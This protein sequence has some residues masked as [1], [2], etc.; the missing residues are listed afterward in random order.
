MFSDNEAYGNGDTGI[1]VEGG[2]GRIVGNHAWGN[3]YGIWA[4]HQRRRRGS[5]RGPRQRRPR[6]QQSASAASTGRSSTATPSTATAATASPATRSDDAR[7]RTTRCIATATGI[8]LSVGAVGIGNRVYANIGTGIE[9]GGGG[10]AVAERNI[11]YDNAVGISESQSRVVNN[12]V[13]DNTTDGIQVYGVHDS[14]RGI[15]NNTVIQPTGTA[16]RMAVNGYNVHIRDNILEVGAG[17]AINVPSNSQSGFTSDYNLFRLT[18]TG[19]V[20][21]WEDR[22]FL[23]LSDWYYETGFDAEGLAA[24]PQF[25]DADGADD[26]RGYSLATIGNGIIIDDGDAGFST[27]GTWTTVIGRTNE[28][29]PPPYTAT[30]I[31]RTVYDTAYGRDIQQI[32]GGGDGQ[33][34]A[35]WTFDGLADGTYQIGARWPTGSGLAPNQARYRVYD[36]ELDVSNVVA[37]ATLS[38]STVN[39]FTADGTSWETLDTVEI[40]NGRL[41]VELSNAGSSTSNRIIADAVRIQR[42]Q[43]DRGT[44]D[45]F[46]LAGDFAGGGSRRSELRVPTG[47]RQQR[48]PR[49]S[50]RLSATPRSRRRALRNWCRC[51]IRTDWRKSK[52]ARA[53]RSISARPASRPTTRSC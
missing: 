49:R 44:D 52:S 32:P 51:S 2:G 25:I 46:R 23:T 26:I 53:S 22:D 45:N 47:A 18:G 7:C 48:C 29:G 20:A 50:R 13:Y 35:R 17:Y 42:I 30:A 9:L 41:I 12:L 8:S 40:R 6:Q 16:L 43:G 39:D 27:I 11:V 1:Q 19:K 38:Q 31:E 21:F 34:V 33:S 10:G 4:E 14:Y 5:H 3:G 28:A 37:I 24:D 15:Y 36:G